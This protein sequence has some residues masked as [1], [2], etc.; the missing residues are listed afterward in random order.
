MV[1]TQSQLLSREVYLIEKVD[2][3]QREK[4]KHLKCIAF[5]RPT[6]ETIQ[7]LVEELRDPCYSDYYIC[8]CFF[9]GYVS[10]SIFECMVDLLLM[11]VIIVDFSNTIRKSGIERLAEADEGEVVRE[12]QVII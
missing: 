5:V 7:H 6:P 2:N 9:S 12:V 3:H 11:A 10:F 4:M 8:T 1:V